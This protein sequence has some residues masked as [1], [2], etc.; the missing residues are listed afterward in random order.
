VQLFAIGEQ[1]GNK[2]FAATKY[3]SGGKPPNPER[4]N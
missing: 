2:I 1:L 4:Q 3:A